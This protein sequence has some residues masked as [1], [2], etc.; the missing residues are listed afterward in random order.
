MKKRI[1]LFTIILFI[2][3]L[4]T[5]SC[6]AATSDSELPSTDSFEN[7]IVIKDKDRSGNVVYYLF[8]CIGPFYKLIHYDVSG[9]QR[10]DFAS[11]EGDT[12]LS[13]S[14]IQYNYDKS[15]NSWVKKNDNLISFLVYFS[16][17]SS[18]ACERTIV[19]SSSAVYNKDGTVFFQALTP[20]ARVVKEAE[21]KQV[22]KEIV[23]LLAPVMIF[24]VA[25]IAL[26][27]GLAF[28]MTLRKM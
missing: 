25:L 5:S 1:V 12:N 16:T 23:T 15:S 19:K 9:G 13:G 3:F 8:N 22:M 14:F 27:K 4:F 21:P 24:L 6:Y 20:M 28:L 10:I 11:I 26:K 18:W 2:L 17:D 7:Y